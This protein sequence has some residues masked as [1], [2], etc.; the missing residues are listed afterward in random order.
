MEEGTE[1]KISER[2]EEWG[3]LKDSDRCLL[4]ETVERKWK[5]WRKQ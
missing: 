5:D 4:R 3:E 1:T 2:R